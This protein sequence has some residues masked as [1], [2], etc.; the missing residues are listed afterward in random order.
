MER[1]RVCHG[2]LGSA[3]TRALVTA[4]DLV[5]RFDDRA[6]PALQG[7]SFRI[8]NG[9]RIHLSG[10]SGSGKSTLTSLLSGTANWSFS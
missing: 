7:C 8:G 4:R 9:D 10:P 1:S 6:E 5:F 3:P 2:L